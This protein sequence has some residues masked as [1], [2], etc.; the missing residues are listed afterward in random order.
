MFGGYGTIAGSSPGT[1]NNGPH[2]DLW[3]WDGSYWTW[4][5]GGNKQFNNGVQGAKGQASSS[6]YPAGRIGMAAWTFDETK[7]YLWGG[8]YGLKGTILK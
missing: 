4:I 7:V 1:F 3:Q 5:A 2:N 8:T 6:Y